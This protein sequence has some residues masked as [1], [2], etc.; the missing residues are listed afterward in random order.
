MP[1]CFP[2]HPDD[3]LT[4]LVPPPSHDNLAVRCGA[5]LTAVPGK[6]AQVPFNFGQGDGGWGFGSG[7]GS[8]GSKGARVSLKTGSWSMEGF[9]VDTPITLEPGVERRGNIQVQVPADAPHRSAGVLEVRQVD[10]RTRRLLG[11]LEIVVVHD[12]ASPEPPRNLR[13]VRQKNIVILSWD[14]VTREEM[15]GLDEQVAAYESCGMAGRGATETDAD[16]T[17]PGFQW[18]EPVAAGARPRYA[19]RAIDLSGNESRTRSRR[20]QGRTSRPRSDTRRSRARVPHR[21]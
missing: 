7:A 16:P 18:S 2:N 17:R 11:S 9:P 20:R 14:I 21:I 5:R 1:G 3:P 12:D 8:S 10:L 15:T 6:I 4:T 13:E 19:V